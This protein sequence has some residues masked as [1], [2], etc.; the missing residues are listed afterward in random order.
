M[1]T[2][3]RSVGPREVFF[4]FQ[5]RRKLLREH[6]RASFENFHLFPVS[7]SEIVWHSF[8]RKTVFV[9]G[10]AGRLGSNELRIFYF[11]FEFYF[12]EIGFVKANITS[13]R[14]NFNICWSL[15]VLYLSMEG[16]TPYIYKP[17]FQKLRV[18]LQQC[19][20][21]WPHTPWK[22]RYIGWVHTKT[23]SWLR[24][25]VLLVQIHFLDSQNLSIHLYIA[26]WEIYWFLPT[27]PL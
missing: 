21:N 18:H 23:L 6:R 8:V 5:I 10:V 25:C 12:A 11:C 20:W 19:L 4:F 15:K 27:L 16:T 3:F 1:L 24:M 2:D 22:K 17:T 14:N 13:L 26:V 9:W 7:V